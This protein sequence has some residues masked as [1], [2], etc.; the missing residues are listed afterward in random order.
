MSVELPWIRVSKAVVRAIIVRV[1]VGRV[2]AAEYTPEGLAT[3]KYK[4][5]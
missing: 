1:I 2:S 5:T 3:T 4:L